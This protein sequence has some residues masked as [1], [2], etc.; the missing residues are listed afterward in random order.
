M[1]ARVQLSAWAKARPGITYPPAEAVLCSL[2]GEGVP[3]AAKRRASICLPTS[4]LTSAVWPTPPRHPKPALSAPASSSAAPSPTSRAMTT[5]RPNSAAIPTR[6]PS[7]V[8][9]SNAN[10]SRAWRISRGRGDGGLFPPEDRP[11]VH[12]LRTQK[13]ANVG[14]AQ[15]HWSLDDL[16]YQILKDAHYRDM[17]RS[18]IQRIL[19]AAELKPHR[20]R[21]WLHSDDP[22]FEAKALAIC[23]LYLD[24]PRLYR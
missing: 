3:C 13:P 20:C 2:S 10:A 23:R 8:A 6:F 11:Q 16:A 18:T 14:L 7:G 12:A 17:S 15:S 24:A 5:S 1:N 9:A 21:C 4:S 22:D 19:A